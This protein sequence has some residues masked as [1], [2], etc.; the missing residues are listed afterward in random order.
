MYYRTRVV[1]HVLFYSR[2]LYR[3]IFSRGACGC[4]QGRM[5]VGG[6][7]G[8]CQ[9]QS[10]GRFACVQTRMPIHCMFKVTCT[11]SESIVRNG[12][13]YSAYI[14]FSDDSRNT[15]LH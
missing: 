14:H 12:M 5:N 9:T 10:I 1:L 7:V 11:P 13:C 8:S 2:S 3:Q 6:G 4:V 15:P